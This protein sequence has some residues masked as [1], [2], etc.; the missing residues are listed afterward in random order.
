MKL[1]DYLSLFKRP[2]SEEEL[3]T[4]FAQL[5]PHFIYGGYINVNDTYKI[6]IRTVEFYFH[7][8]H[9]TA[10]AIKDPIVYHRNPSQCQ[11]DIPYFPLMSL[12]AH[13][14][15]ID[16]TFENEEQRYRASALIRE[17]S[18]FDIKANRFLPLK[19]DGRDD[20]S[21]FLY[22]YLNGFTLNGSASIK[23]IDA[24][25]TPTKPLIQSTRRGVFEYRDGEKTK[26]HDKRQWS[27]KLNEDIWLPID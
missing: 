16:I 8:E 1:Y 4:N 3:T 25:H 14:S 5:A 10:D 6:Y 15:G 7:D 18:V 24:E 26:E 12:N 22:E 17:F 13:I 23:W 9:D 11:Y 2:I 27:F 21:T 19:K 20:R